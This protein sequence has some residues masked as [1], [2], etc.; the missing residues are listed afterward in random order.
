MRTGPCAFDPAANAQP[1]GPSASCLFNSP[2]SLSSYSPIALG[3]LWI[4][5]KSTPGRWFNIKASLTEMVR[6][7]T[8]QPL[9]SSS[10]TELIIL[11]LFRE[12]FSKDSSVDVFEVSNAN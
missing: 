1:R 3:R 12:M 11:F 4:Q 6:G 9:T 10:V 8:K 5:S 2:R 7:K